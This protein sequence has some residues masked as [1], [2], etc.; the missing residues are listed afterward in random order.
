MKKKVMIAAGVVGAGVF[1][2]YV[3]KKMSCG[4]SSG[5]SSTS[6]AFYNDPDASYPDL[7][8]HNNH[9]SNCLTPR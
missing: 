2:F 3:V 8:K 4:G 5:Q 9:M 7:S 6:V 1:G